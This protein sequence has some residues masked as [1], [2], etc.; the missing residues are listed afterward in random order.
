MM[1]SDSLANFIVAVM[2]AACIAGLV[3]MILWDE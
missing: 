3:G 2:I 1:T